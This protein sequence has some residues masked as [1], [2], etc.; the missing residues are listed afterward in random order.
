MIFAHL[1]TMNTLKGEKRMANVIVVGGG[2]SG[3]IAAG[4]AA[5][6]G[7]TVHLYEKK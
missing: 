3:M 5:E 7:H 2:T 4:R 6:K 1:E